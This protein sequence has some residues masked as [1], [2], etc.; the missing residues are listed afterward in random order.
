MKNC[1]SMKSA[2]TPTKRQNATITN[3]EKALGKERGHDEVR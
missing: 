2:N 3:A 1:F